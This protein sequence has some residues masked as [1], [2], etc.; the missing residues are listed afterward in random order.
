M[1][2]EMLAEGSLAVIEMET[3]NLFPREML[4]KVF[5]VGFDVS[6]FS[7]IVSG[8]EEMAGIETDGEPIRLLRMLYKVSEV[9]CF[10][11]QY[12]TLPSS[13]FKSDLGVPLVTV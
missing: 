7:H 11:S 12:R 6:L 3:E 1:P 8:C 4:P 13:R 10:G 5:Q 2:I 9:G